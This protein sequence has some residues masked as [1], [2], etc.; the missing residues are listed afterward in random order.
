ME[1]DAIVLPSGA[2]AEAVEIDGRPA[3]GIVSCTVS[4]R[5]DEWLPTIE[6]PLGDSVDCTDRPQTPPST[7]IDPPPTRSS[8]RARACSVGS[9]EQGSDPPSNPQAHFQRARA[10]GVATGDAVPTSIGLA[11]Q[12][13]ANPTNQHVSVESG[14]PASHKASTDHQYATRDQ[15]SPL[16]KG[17][18]AEKG[19]QYVISDVRESMR[20]LLGRRRG[21]LTDELRAAAVNL[22]IGISEFELANPQSGDAEAPE[23]AGIGKH[24]RLHAGSAKPH[25]AAPVAASFTREQ[26]IAPRGNARHIESE[27]IQTLRAEAIPIFNPQRYSEPEAPPEPSDATPPGPFTTAQLIPQAVYESVVKHG[28]TTST[29]VLERAARGANGW[30]AAKSLRP[31]PLIYSEE[32]AL[33]PCGRGR[34]WYQPDPSIDRWW[35]LGN[36][37]S[38]HGL[39]DRSENSINVDAFISRAK[40]EGLTDNRLISWL[41]H[42]FPGPSSIPSGVVCIGGPHVGALKHVKVYNEINRR[43]VENKFVTA[44]RAFPEMWPTRVDYT[45]LVMQNGKGR[46][47]I[48]KRIQLSSSRHPDPL[49]AYNDYI[50]LEQDRELGGALS[51]FPATQFCRGA[52]ILMT[53]CVDSTISRVKFGK[54]DK[55]TFFRMHQ[56]RLRAIPFSGRL[57]Q[58]GFGMDWRVNF[59]E[60]DAMDHCCAA[61]DATAFFV[62]K[63][64]A[65]IAEEY[66]TQDPHVI[67]WLLER[68]N[69]IPQ[70]AASNDQ[71]YQ[72]AT[73]FIFAFFV[74]DGNLLAI[75]SPMCRKDGSPVMELDGKGRPTQVCIADFMLTASRGVAIEIGYGAPDK[76]F[77]SMRLDLDCIGCGV[78]LADGRSV[79]EARRYLPCEKRERYGRDLKALTAE[80]SILPNGLMAVD[81]SDA[82]SLV[83]KLIHA[84][85]SDVLGR[86][87][88]HYIRAALRDHERHGNNLARDA[89]V[90]PR[91]AARELAW[92]E[93]RLGQRVSSL[94]LASRLNFPSSSASTLVH[95]IDASREEKHPEQSGLGGGSILLAKLFYVHD[96]WSAAEV[97]AFSINT[98]EGFT[99]DAVATRMLQQ[100][101]HMGI[102]ITH[103]QSYV[104]NSTAENVAERGRTQSDAMSELQKRRIERN[105]EWGVFETTERIA[106][107]DNVVADLLSRGDIEDA[108]R[109]AQEAG[110]PAYRLRLTPEQRDTSWVPRTWA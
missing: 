81:R 11:N 6:E 22:G 1:A 21:A 2:L 23:T 86:P 4:S 94:P 31:E 73:T 66:P 70:G 68:L 34:Q 9:V 63:E 50:D 25:E 97:A 64:L 72:W 87:N 36:K 38:D 3:P 75:A 40:H 104:D 46:V 32:E 18:K 107:A 101:K 44:G 98:L 51:L 43:D 5:N 35:A 33:H 90:M 110:I 39:P 65:R 100:A 92:W 82:H 53:A 67:D 109:F 52:A 77:F 8:K 91:K 55:A 20:A 79:L 88:L 14:Q 95:Y 28:R 30:R 37:R 56:K 78:D 58:D 106:S 15:A 105:L 99:K 17:R 12:G 29:T 16:P 69:L 47:T 7:V 83:H 96:R 62:R 13:S 59:G 89:V 102:S 45:N 85:E 76:K 93:S 71:R 10:K 49:P 41:E 84:S 74:D 24:H 103:L 19:D 42:D 61:S 57:N 48:D 80:A 26:R 27:S 108:L 60:R 54:W